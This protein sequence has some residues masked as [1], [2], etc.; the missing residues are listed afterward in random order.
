MSG[1]DVAVT[2]EE[3]ILAIATLTREARA[4]T[5]RDR[6]TAA[7]EMGLS[8][9]TLQLIEASKNTKPPTPRTQR[10]IETYYG[11]RPES[12]A[13]VWDNRR[14]IQP[15]ELTLETM[16]PPKPAG[17]V[18]ASHLTDAELMAELNFR[19]LMRDSR[20]GGE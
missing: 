11:W 6:K 4:A 15:G 14:N 8:D 9:G 16:L 3:T 5:G 12:L 2:D 10:A 20:N 18:K 1:Y 19:F 17:L 13:E 7:R